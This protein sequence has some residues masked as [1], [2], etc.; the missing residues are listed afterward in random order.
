MP[1]IRVRAVG[2]RLHPDTNG[3][4]GRF[5]GR[6]YDRSVIAEGVLVTD[7]GDHRR[8]IDCGDLELVPD[9]PPR[10]VRSGKENG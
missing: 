6:A 10:A 3:I 2:D 7:D 9:A 1:Q 8:A 4:P 5:T